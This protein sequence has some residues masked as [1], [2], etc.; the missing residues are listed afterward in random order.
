MDPLAPFGRQEPCWCG[1]GKTYRL[2]HKRWAT[3]QSQP[4]DPTPPDPEDA[5]FLSPRVS[6][7]RGALSN[8]M[9][10][11]TPI[12]MPAAPSEPRPSPLSYVEHAIATF[13]TEEPALSVRD[14]GR[15]RVDL[16]HRLS[17]LPDNT[18]E[19]QLELREGVAQAALLAWQ[20][21]GTL[22]LTPATLLWNEEL[23]PATFIGRTILLADHV[24][25]PDRILAAA[26]HRTTNAA[27]R[28]LARTELRREGLIRT[29]RVISVPSGPALATGGDAAYEAARLD[30]TNAELTDFIR[31]QLVIEG[32]TAREAL[33][34][35]A[36]DDFEHEPHMW[37]YA[38]FVPGSVDEDGHFQ[39]RMLGHFDPQ[40]DYQPW[41]AQTI[42]DAVR[43]YVQRTADR[44][45]VA[46]LV[47]AEYV[48]ASPFEARLLRR[49]NP[50]FTPGP[51][52]AGVWADVPVLRS[53]ES[54]DLVKILNE[55]EAVHDLRGRVQ[56][57]V[58]SASDLA[59][60]AKAIQELT[61]ELDHS[62]AILDR[63][64]RTERAYSAITPAALGTAGLVIGAAGGV[65]GFAGA[66]IGAVAG[67]V[68]WIGAR[69][70]ARRDAAYL[71][72]TARRRK[73]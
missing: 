32:P 31:D 8:A 33:F 3:P 57:A 22:A 59:G 42:D 2:C 55:D 14:L 39:T 6:L 70:N 9:P 12:T 61:D 54:K 43:A 69:R 27:L 73:R 19:V 51:A 37:L 17:R 41:I 71:F 10:A 38:H 65:P 34:V 36:K 18:D 11:G 50:T 29:G 44:L 46:D 7:A 30:L 25:T 28:H 35:N 13:P 16:L 4:G 52:S 56:L 47:G 1:S 5:I 26:S 62:S 24:L 64:L 60:Q 63:K 49:R 72:V 20:T 66:A 53:L 21:V 48:A 67:I 40:H 23:D 68:P 15:L 45:V 58:K